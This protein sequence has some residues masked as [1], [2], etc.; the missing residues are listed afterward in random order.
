MISAV[1]ICSDHFFQES[2]FFNDATK[3]VFS[4]CPELKNGYFHPNDKPGW[5]VDIDETKAAKYP[6]PENP[7]YW[8]PVRRRDG[9]AVRP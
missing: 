8:E 1:K 7:G 2:I 5:G 6:F 3:E 9:T 4:G